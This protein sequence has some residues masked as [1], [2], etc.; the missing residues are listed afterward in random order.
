MFFLWPLGCSALRFPQ[1]CGAVRLGCVVQVP[2]TGLPLWSAAY[3]YVLL[4]ALTRSCQ[5]NHTRA[6]RCGLSLAAAP[7]SLRCHTIPDS[8]P[9]VFLQ[10]KL[11]T[12]RFLRGII[13]ILGPSA[14]TIDDLPAIVI[15]IVI[16][17]LVPL[18]NARFIPLSFPL[19]LYSAQF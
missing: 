8:V 1:E 18:V 5:S 2:L 17:L 11:G 7:L 13:I 3:S 9:F 19:R 4:T 14:L 15:P 12:V 6:V 16:H 10:G